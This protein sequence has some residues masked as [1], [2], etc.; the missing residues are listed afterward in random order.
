MMTLLALISY[1]VRG[2]SAAPCIRIDKYTIPMSGDEMIF[3]GIK[4][5]QNAD[6]ERWI[7]PYRL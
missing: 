2:I 7:N 6:G 1:Y 5:M 3:L 4:S